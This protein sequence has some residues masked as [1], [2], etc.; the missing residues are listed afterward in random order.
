MLGCDKL[1]VALDHK[2]LLGVLND[3]SLD[4]IENPRIQGLKEKTLRYRFS[5]VHMAGIKNKVADNASR[6]P[7]SSP[8]HQEMAIM[9]A[10]GNVNNR[11]IRETLGITRQE[12]IETDWDDSKAIEE[13]VETG[14]APF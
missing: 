6:F 1:M 9:E 3:K 7:T 10:A 2:P 13:A 4:D 11:L 5:I 12:P 14:N 8:E